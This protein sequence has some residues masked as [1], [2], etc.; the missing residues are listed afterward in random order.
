M[1]PK[2]RNSRKRTPT[3][4]NGAPLSP[5]PDGTSVPKTPAANPTFPFVTSSHHPLKS[6]SPAVD[7]VVVER[8][9]S[10]SDEDRKLFLAHDFEKVSNKPSKLKYYN[11]IYLFNPRTSSRPSHLKDSLKNAFLTEVRP[12]LKPHLLPAPSVSVRTDCP[13]DFDPLGRQTTRQMLV[14]AIHQNAPDA[15]IP[16]SASVDDVLILYKKYV[17]PDLKLP[18]NKRFT[19][20]P[21]VVPVNRLKN[22][23]MEDILVAL[24]YFAPCLFVRSLAMNKETL[25]DLYIQ[26]VRDETPSSEL[27]PG[28]H[29]TILHLTASDLDLM[30]TQVSFSL[31]QTSSSKYVMNE[32]RCF[33]E[34]LTF[35]YFLL[36]I[37]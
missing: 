5:P 29:Y 4:D 25:M 28:F 27:I 34:L 15:T 2:K 20:R 10:L 36:L 14:T 13:S 23:S 21:R 17:D 12:L 22:E 37:S 16:A 3:V 11:I 19:A 18:V 31:L 33:S 32:N 24:R 30:D 26:F 8:I 9:Q 1:P 35:T 6:P 7:K